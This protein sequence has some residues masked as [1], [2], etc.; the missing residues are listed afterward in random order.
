MDTIGGPQFLQT[1]FHPEEGL[2]ELQVSLGPPKEKR[3]GDNA[4]RAHSGKVPVPE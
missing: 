3:L 1:D 4:Y 2:W